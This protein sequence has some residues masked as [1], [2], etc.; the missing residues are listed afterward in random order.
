MKSPSHSEVSGFHIPNAPRRFPGG[1]VA[2][3]LRTTWSSGRRNGVWELI[4]LCEGT[5]GPLISV[6]PAIEQNIAS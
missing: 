6:P 3:H 1:V 2:L 4:C 5:N